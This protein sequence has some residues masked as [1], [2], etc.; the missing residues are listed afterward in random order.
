VAAASHAPAEEKTGHFEGYIG[1]LMRRSSPIK[2]GKRVEKRH[3]PRGEI[4][5]LN[6]VERE[7]SPPFV[8]LAFAFRS[9]TFTLSRPA[10][11]APAGL[12]E[13]EE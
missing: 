5:F 8:H 3:F 1:I 12:E 9:R 10:T 4:P 13:V 7:A 2:G 6:W 11:V